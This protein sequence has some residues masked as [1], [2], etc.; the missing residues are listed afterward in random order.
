MIPLILA[1]L[2][3]SLMATIYMGSVI[4]PVAHLHGLPGAVVNEDTG[5]AA[6]GRQ[7]QTGDNIVRA[8]AGSP[9]VSRRL[10][11]E[12]VSLAEAKSEMDHAVGLVRVAPCPV[13]RLKALQVPPAQR[14]AL[15]AWEP[16]RAAGRRETGVAM[17]G[18]PMSESSR[19]SSPA[20]GAR[21]SASAR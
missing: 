8:L 2:F 4:D 13:E 14:V 1:A 9:D 5:A 3:I 17:S 10:R 15:A 11:L 21:R 20:A 19:I 16:V 6:G 7:I 12:S 18:A